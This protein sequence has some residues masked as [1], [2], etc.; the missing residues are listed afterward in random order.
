MRGK[1]GAFSKKFQ[2]FCSPDILKSKIC[3]KDDYLFM[4]TIPAGEIRKGE[5]LKVR[6]SKGQMGM[7]AETAFATE[8]IRFA[9]GS[10][11]QAAFFQRTLE[12]IPLPLHFAAECAQR[13]SIRTNSLYR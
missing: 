12:R 2:S 3:L 9:S 1:P 5:Y 11:R 8:T 13:I 10:M 4:H 6:R 7:R